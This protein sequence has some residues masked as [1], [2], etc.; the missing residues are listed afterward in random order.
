MVDDINTIEPQNTSEVRDYIRNLK[1]QQSG[2]S[3]NLSNIGRAPQFLP[4]IQEINRSF[5]KM[6]SPNNNFESQL[7][8]EGTATGNNE[9]LEIQ[10]RL[11]IDIPV[12]LKKKGKSPRKNGIPKIVREKALKLEEMIYDKRYHD[13]RNT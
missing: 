7:F 4:E 9:S 3:K 6:N 5:T 10:G 11:D 1:A 13:F 2:Y 12:K 8:I